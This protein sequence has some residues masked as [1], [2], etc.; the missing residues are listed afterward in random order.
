MRFRAATRQLQKQTRS[1]ILRRLKSQVETSLKP[2]N[3]V[4]VR[5]ALTKLQAKWYRGIY[6][7]NLEMLQGKN[8]KSLSLMN[9]A[10]SQPLEMCILLMKNGVPA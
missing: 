2:L 10:A 1:H 3:E 6:S 8:G 7:K 9:T 4:I 5:V